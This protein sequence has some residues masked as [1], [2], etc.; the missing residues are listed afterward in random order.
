MES[1]VLILLAMIVVGAAL[2]VFGAW[3]YNQ[4]QKMEENATSKTV[5]MGASYLMS[6]GGILVIAGGFLLNQLLH[7]LER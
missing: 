1:T 4:N 6:F 3:K 2:F 5:S 7:G